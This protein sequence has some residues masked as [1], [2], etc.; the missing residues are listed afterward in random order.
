M[1][2]HGGLTRGQMVIDRSSARHNVTIVA[3]LDKNKVI[4]MLSSA[5]DK[6]EAEL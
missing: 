6:L 2:L 3:G 1:E 4:G 5:M